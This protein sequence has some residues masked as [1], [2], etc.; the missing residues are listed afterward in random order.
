MTARISELERQ[1]GMNPRNS[2]KPPSSEGLTKP[3][4]R[5]RSLRKKT[6]R[7][8]GGQA[9]AVRP[10]PGHRPRMWWSPTPRRSAPTAGPD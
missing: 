9:T 6:G 2:S 3:A 4:T 1:L 8:P 5:P 7:K 10:W